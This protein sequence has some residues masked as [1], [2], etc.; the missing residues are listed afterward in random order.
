[1][2]DLVSACQSWDIIT[3]FDIYNFEN[4]P[5]TVKYVHNVSLWWLDSETPGLVFSV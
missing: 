4:A 1:M 5:L 3:I 2:L